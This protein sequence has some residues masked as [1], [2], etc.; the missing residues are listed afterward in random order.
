MNMSAK[1]DEGTPTMFSLEAQLKEL[2]VPRAPDIWGG[3]SRWWQIGYRDVLLNK[4]TPLGGHGSGN[5]YSAG[6]RAAEE[7]AR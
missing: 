4:Y 6:R 5:A 3:N 1:H 2:D 7:A